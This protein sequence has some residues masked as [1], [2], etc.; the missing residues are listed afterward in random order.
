MKRS[1]IGIDEKIERQK[2]VVSQA[3]DKYDTELTK[4]E[5]LMKKRR[6]LQKKELID[7]FETSDRTLTEVQEFLKDRA[8]DA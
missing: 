8:E 1:Q 6:E 2:H 7:A 4:L 5:N 3:K